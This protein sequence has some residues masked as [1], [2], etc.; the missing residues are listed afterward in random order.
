[1]LTLS[2]PFGGLFGLSREFEDVFGHKPSNGDQV[3]FAPAVD[4]EERA[5]HFLVSADLPGVSE[6]DIEVKV[7]DGVL[8]LSGKREVSKEEKTEAGCYRERSSGSFCRTF[9]LGDG[10]DPEKIEAAYKNGV[11][12]VKLPKK[13]ETKPRQIPV[14]TN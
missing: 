5:D 1:M 13:E 10:V 9:T 11:L 3:D 12:T 8:L 7:Q 2:R 4:I 6:K 14:S